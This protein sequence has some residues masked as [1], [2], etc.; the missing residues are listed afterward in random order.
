MPPMPSPVGPHIIAV[1]G[2]DAS[3][4]TTQ[5]KLL[6]QQLIDQGLSVS[7]L[8][9]PRYESFFGTRIGTLLSGTETVTANSLDPRSMALWF[10]MDRWDA[11]RTYGT[12]PMSGDDVIILNRWTLS[13]AVYQGARA[14]SPTEA[15]AVFD[16]VLELERNVLALPSPSLTVMLDISVETSMNRATNRAAQTGDRPDVYESKAALLQA[17]RRLYQRAAKQGHGMLINVDNRTV[18]EVEIDV[19]TLVNQLL[20]Q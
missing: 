19:L 15:D 17:S 2:L 18:E 6:T 14:T 10:A 9:F 11:M 3:G 20:N 8:S 1:E 13:N 7:E 5:A 16:W 4:K 12:G